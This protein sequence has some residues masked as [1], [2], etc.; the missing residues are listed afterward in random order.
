MN[1]ILC[2]LCLIIVSC[3]NQVNTTKIKINYGALS[4]QDKFKHGMILHAENLSADKVGISIFPGIDAHHDDLIR[5]L[6]N[7]SNLAE[8]QNGNWIFTG[9]GYH[10]SKIIFCASEEVSLTG[11]EEVINLEFSADNCTGASSLLVGMQEFREG[12]S[13]DGNINPTEV[14]LCSK[15]IYKDNCIKNESNSI[16]CISECDRSNNVSNYNLVISYY[17]KPVNEGF[18]PGNNFSFDN[19]LS[20]QLDSG[21]ENS[22]VLFYGAVNSNVQVSLYLFFLDGVFVFPDVFTSLEDS[23]INSKNLVEKIHSPNGFEGFM[24]QEFR[25]NIRIFSSKLIADELEI[26]DYDK[27]VNQAVACNKNYLIYCVECSGS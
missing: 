16:G 4:A 23:S 2:F 6:D 14:I 24:T 20:G 26:T 9:I 22:N 27:C 11:G 25:P 19:S 15:E 17:G 10:E 18:D 7:D 1:L 5:R 3:H 21:K 13:I 8:L 12:W